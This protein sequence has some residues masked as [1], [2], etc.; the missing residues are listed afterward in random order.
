M[1]QIE[2]PE[3][4]KGAFC[5]RNFDDS[6][7]ARYQVGARAS[8]QRDTGVI[9]EAVAG[10]GVQEHSKGDLYPAVIYA[11]GRPSEPYSTYSHV[12]L[13]DGREEEYASHADAEEVARA[14]LASPFLR[15][16]WHHGDVSGAEVA[17]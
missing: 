3:R 14:L 15:A 9:R 5:P 12:L 11:R 4:R 10:D 7:R 13:L 17:S 16:Q 6:E 8:L 1:D 2:W